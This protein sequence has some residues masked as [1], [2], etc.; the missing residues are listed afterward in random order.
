MIRT[1][2][3]TKAEYKI[4]EDRLALLMHEKEKIF[5]KFFPISAQIS[6][7]PSHTNL[8]VDKMAEY[9]A[10]LTRV[11]DNGKSLDQEITDVRNELQLREYYL[12]RM[13]LVLESTTGIENELFYLIAV[14][15]YRP[16]RAVEFVAEKYKKEPITIWK[17]NYSKIKDEISKCIVN[18]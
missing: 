2:A 7:N 18:V 9:M 14:K 16:T 13:E 4:Y 1:Y 3:N 10:E 5:T 17:Y 15:G 11:R 12:K 6:D 8:N